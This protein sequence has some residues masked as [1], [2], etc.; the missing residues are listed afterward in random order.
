M[1]TNS[2]E[3]NYCVRFGHSLWSANQLLL[4][5]QYVRNIY[6]YTIYIVNV[7]QAK[8]MISLSLL[9]NFDLVISYG[10]IQKKR[11]I[12]YGSVIRYGPRKGLTEHYAHL[13]ERR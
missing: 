3:K 1:P 9:N 12:L 6:N 13:R 10:R 7:T 2:K 8:Q 5:L 11:I 4:M